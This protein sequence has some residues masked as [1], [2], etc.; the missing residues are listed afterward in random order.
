MKALLI[1]EK[2]SLAKDIKQVY[3]TMNYKDDITFIS[4][5][6]HVLELKS[7]EEYNSQWGQPWKLEV[8]PMI[9]DKFEYKVKVEDVFNQAKNEIIS[10]KYDYII[11]ACDAGREGEL[12]FYSV[13]KHIGKNIPVKRFWASD[14]T[15]ETVKKALENLIDDKESSLTALKASA[16]FRSYFD[17]L[18]GMNLSRAITLKTGKLIPCGRVMTP[19]LGIVVQREL[20]ITNFKPKDFWEIEANFGKYKGTWFDKESNET[21]ILDKAKANEIVGALDKAG[22]V[23]SITKKEEINYAPTLHS[24]LE[25]QKEANKEFGY[26][27]DKTLAVAQT[28]YEKRKLLSYPRT[29]SRY[30]PK[31]LA[32]M[33]PKHLEC[34]RDIPDVENHVNLIL[35]DKKRISDIVSS[36]KY[37]DDKKVTDHHAIIP[38]QIKPKLMELSDEELNIYMLVVRRFVSIFLNPFVVNKTTIVTNVG[39]EKFKTTGR[40]LVDLGYKILYKSDIN[41]DII[42]DVLK[43]E[44]VT[45]NNVDLITKQTKPPARYD[46][47]SLLQAMQ[48]AG[49]FIDDKELQ[50]VLKESAGLGTSAT[51]ADVIKKLVDREMLER[52]GTGKIKFIVPTGFGMTIY[53]ILKNQDIISPELTAVWEKKLAD[54]ESETYDIKQ[55]YLE[56]KEY[57][58]VVTRRFIDEI[59]H[60]MG[61]SNLEVIG[62]CP[63][64]KKDVLI[65]KNFYFCQDYKNEKTEG[66]CSFVFSKKFGGTTINKTELKKLLDGK[67]TKEM[68]FT[69]KSGSKSTVSLKLKADGSLDFISSNAKSSTTSAASNEV[70]GKCPNPNCKSNVIDKSN[71][72]MCESYKNGCDF[73]LSKT[74]SGAKISQKDA[75]ALISG[76]ETSEMEFTWKSGNKGKS[77]LKL[78]ALK[79]EFNF[80]K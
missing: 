14:T 76:K 66:S 32:N 70:I 4:L 58:D 18:L 33:I 51:R 40:T 9:P 7:P 5:R 39:A 34:L 36:K 38:T 67:Q 56:M 10:G 35:S 20:E 29:E 45:V 69:W 3:E 22:K 15:P 42:P 30:L 77:T 13:Y 6:G 59:N 8:L 78:N 72:Y 2:P 21:K 25:L 64:C 1:A 60:F 68:E 12:I 23:E 16:Q 49:K 52:K 75:K 31:N 19:T 43:G 44:T 74:I 73:I 41:N 17:W 63:I 53:E 50:S 57:T 28:L 55:F 47:S 27:A 37:V 80:N 62:K 48:N 71:F 61:N 65:G 46:D 26:T 54:I 24:L 11:N 79:L